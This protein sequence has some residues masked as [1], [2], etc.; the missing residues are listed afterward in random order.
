MA[1]TRTEI[2]AAGDTKAESS[3]VSVELGTMA[4]VCL[5]GA[6]NGDLVVLEIQDDAG[7]WQPTGLVLTGQSPSQS[8][9]GPGNYRLV[10][11]SGGACGAFKVV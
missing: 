11:R 4:T 9:I 10:R 1:V 3:V 6:T 8:L 5:K 7:G 2:L